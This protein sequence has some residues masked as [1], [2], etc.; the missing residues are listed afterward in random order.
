MRCGSGRG[1]R[2]VSG[3]A[4]RSSWGKIGPAEP[5]S[6]APEGLRCP[7]L[8]QRPESRRS[9]GGESLIFRASS[10]DRSRPGAPL[11]QIRTQPRPGASQ[12]GYSGVVL[13]TWGVKVVG[14]GLLGSPP[15]AAGGAALNS[16]AVISPSPPGASGGS[17]VGGGPGGVGGGS[18]APSPLRLDSASRMVGRRL[19]CRDAPRLAS[20]SLNPRDRHLTREIVT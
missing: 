14:D 19:A 2:A 15:G 7:N 8:L 20:T 4:P 10:R 1:L 13:K 16:S 12:E 6:G 9:T 11:Q 5:A 18:G 3:G 17:G